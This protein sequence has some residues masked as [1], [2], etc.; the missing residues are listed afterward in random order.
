MNILNQEIRSKN[1]LVK[2]KIVGIGL[3]YI[4][5]SFIKEETPITL[6]FEQFLNNC[7]CSDEVE[8]FVLELKMNVKEVETKYI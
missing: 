1:T 8:E 2:G 6:T 7:F 5:V 3:N 4:Q